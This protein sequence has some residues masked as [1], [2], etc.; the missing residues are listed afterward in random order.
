MALFA[1]HFA[2]ILKLQEGDDCT[3]SS[4]HL[5]SKWYN[6]LKNWNNRCTAVGRPG[7]LKKKK[8]KQLFG[9]I[10]EELLKVTRNIKWRSSHIMTTSKPRLSSPS[11]SV[12]TKTSFLKPRHD[13]PLCNPASLCWD[14]NKKLD[15]YAESCDGARR[16]ELQHRWMFNQSVE[17]LRVFTSRQ[18]KPPASNL[19]TWRLFIKKKEGKKKALCVIRWQLWE[20]CPQTIQFHLLHPIF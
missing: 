7:P 17:R 16:L 18:R 4:I 3:V 13:L 1:L 20:R 9:L 10:N 6:S 14:C 8:Y 12:T 19:F 11:K 2:S 15:S 5:H